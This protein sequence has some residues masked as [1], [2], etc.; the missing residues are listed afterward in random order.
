MCIQD[1]SHSIDMCIS[2]SIY[3]STYLPI[4]LS[5]YLHILSCVI[6]C[7]IFL[8]MYKPK[9][10]HMYMYIYI[11]LH[12]HNTKN[13]ACRPMSMYWEIHWISHDT[14]VSKYT[15]HKQ[16][17]CASPSASPRMQWKLR[18]KQTVYVSLCFFV[19]LQ[20]PT[21]SI[22]IRAYASMWKKIYIYIY[23]YGYWYIYIYI[24]YMCTWINIYIYIYL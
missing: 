21:S 6:M 3:L 1:V 8:D 16:D 18:A 19:P 23:A 7:L 5:I 22:Y 4:Y 11:Y 9:S 12:I 20:V 10:T 17:I 24:F 15:V 14:Y 2:L 13:F